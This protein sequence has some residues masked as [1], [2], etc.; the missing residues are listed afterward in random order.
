[1]KI[2][3]FG[4]RGFIGR[5]LTKRLS[6]M[7]VVFSSD[8]QDEVKENY[9]K[10]D[11]LDRQSV[12]EL[13]KEFKPDIL[14]NLAART[15]L[16]GKNLKDYEVNWQGSVNICESISELNYSPL[17]IHF[18]S[19]LVCK[20][21]HTPNHM[22]EYCPDTVY[23]ES[24]VKSEKV[25]ELYKKR[26]PLLILRPTTVWGDG[27]GKPYSTFISIVSKVGWV[28]LSIFDSKRDFCHISNLVNIMIDLVKVRKNIEENYFDKFYISDNE[29]N[30]VNDLARKISSEKKSLFISLPVFDFSIKVFIRA[31]A[32]F[33]DF[34][35]I[36]HIKFILNKRRIKNMEMTTNLP[37]D[38]L[39]RE[40]NRIEKIK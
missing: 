3:I 29:R 27:A 16:R 40:I 4:S 37:V 30:S 32:L 13:I 31:L 36:I 12:F 38:R 10:L 18:S 35:E 8:I 23:G 15:D 33:G 39:I 1:M 26:F 9:K 7:H 6:S 2:L 24:K 25:L 5:N 17:L 28:K 20:M 14:I 11:I 21:G 22:D 19:M 34:L